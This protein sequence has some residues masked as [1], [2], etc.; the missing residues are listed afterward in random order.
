MIQSIYQ[1]AVESYQAGDF[2]RAEGQYKQV[3]QT[4]PQHILAQVS[5]GYLLEQ[6][7]R[8]PEAITAYKSALALHPEPTITAQTFNNLGNIFRAQGKPQ[9]AIKAYRRALEISP[10]RATTQFNLGQT[11]YQLGKFDHAIRAYQQAIKLEPQFTQAYLH[12]AAALCEKDRLIAA[13]KICQKLLEMT[14]HCSHALTVSGNILQA[15][16][17]LTEAT[18]TYQQALKHN[19]NNAHAYYNLG[20]I[21][22]DQYDFA[23]AQSA[24]ERAITLDPT[25]SAARMGHCFSCLPIIYKDAEAVLK[26]RER[27][28]QRLTDLATYFQTLS[29][30]EKAIAADGVGSFQ[31]FYLAYQ[32]FSDRTL[33]KIYGEM[34]VDLMASRYP[35]WSQP[36]EMPTLERNE[37]IRVGFVSR[38]FYH[39]SNWKIP[40]KGW[41]ENL[42]RV[43]FELFG[44]YTGSIEDSATAAARQTFDQFIQGVGS[45]EQW[46]QKIR[47]DNLHIL[48][49]PEFGMDPTTVKLGCLQLAPIQMTFGGHP[50]TSGMPTIDYHL[51][52]ELMEPENGQ[53]HYTEK[54]INLPNLAFHYTLLDPSPRKRTKQ[55]IGLKADDIM[56]WCCQ[57]LFKYLPQHDDVFPQIAKTLLKEQIKAQF[58]FIQASQ[59]EYI[60]DVFR[61]RLNKAFKAL[62][63]DY[64]NHCTFLPRMDSS[65]FAGTIAIADIFLDSIGWAGDN[66]TMESTAYNLPIVTWPG[67]LMRGRH[68]TAMLKMMGIEETIAASKAEYIALAV[69]LGKDP[70]YRQHIS[71]RIANNKRKLYKDLQ[72]VRALETFFLD[73][74]GKAQ[75]NQSAAVAKDLQLAT[76]AQREHNFSAA[77]RAFQRILQQQPEHPEALYGLGIIAQQKQQ[78]EAATQYLSASVRSQPNAVRTWF[79]LGNLYHEQNRFTSAIIAYRQAL[80][81]RPDSVSILNNLG[82]TL[83]KQTH[84]QEAIDCYQKALDIQPGCLE[85]ESNLGHALHQ[86]QQLAESQRQHYVEINLTLMRAYHQR[87]HQSAAYSYCQQALKL[88]PNNKTAQQFL[89]LTQPDALQLENT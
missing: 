44:Y 77:K 56:F 55:E 16:G 13:D 54:L 39:H 17:Q 20:N 33:Q 75:S 12:L 27:Y 59:S 71:N 57:S 86:T 31:P 48:I 29:T 69:R 47:A 4:Q 78:I 32:G 6:Q 42:N 14:P 84:W 24:F 38:F 64:T 37:K 82:S 68:S 41:V 67:E 89:Q 25:L 7:Q 49:C 23:G 65:T 34:I 22:H 60:T 19:P 2:R 87:G 83:E 46:A 58:V 11:L 80:S 73:I 85:A 9:Q 26:T 50:E 15:R 76:Q 81:R 36:L 1:K 62:D 79:A 10:E 18:K 5:L 28:R 70:N 3:L 40:M 21:C 43:D 30:E 45:I 52:S 88:D 53:D 63:L 51:S 8:L 66:T 72:P 35:Q 74:V 61:Q